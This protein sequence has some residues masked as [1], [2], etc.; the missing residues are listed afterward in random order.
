V[1]SLSDLGGAD[2]LDTGTLWEPGSAGELIFRAAGLEPPQSIVQC[3]GSH[4]IVTLLAN[5][6]MLT[7]TQ[8]HVLDRPPTSESLQE[9]KVDEAMPSV[10]VGLYTRADAPLTRVAA[11]M[12]RQVTAVSREL[13]LK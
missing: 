6:N 8:W 11:A 3:V 1:R 5:C 10:T 9:I 2:W 7:L 4:S 12:M 13:A